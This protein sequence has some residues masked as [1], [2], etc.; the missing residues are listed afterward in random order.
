MNSVREIL[1]AIRALPDDERE[2][3]VEKL[4]EGADRGSAQKPVEEPAEGSA[5]E[6]R[7]GFY[8]YTGPVDLSALDHRAARE[9]RIGHLLAGIGS[10]G[11][12]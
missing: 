7:N 9:D 5:L 10:A 2:R 1:D 12:D 11:R 6:F 8:V 3:L 4:T